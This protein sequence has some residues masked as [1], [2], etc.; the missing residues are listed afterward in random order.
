VRK[1]SN[2]SG[3]LSFHKDEQKLI[4]FVPYLSLEYNERHIIN[5]GPP[6]GTLPTLT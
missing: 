2:K 6:S 3:V 5:P 4:L 1:D